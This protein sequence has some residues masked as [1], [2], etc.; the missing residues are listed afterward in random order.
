MTLRTYQPSRKKRATKHGFLS[1]LKTK[2]GKK[3]ILRRMRKGRKQL[4][5]KT[6]KK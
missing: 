4:A 6:N 5:V 1:R 3:V 2:N